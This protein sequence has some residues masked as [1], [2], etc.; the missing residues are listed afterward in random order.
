MTFPYRSIVKH[1]ETFFFSGKFLYLVQGFGTQGTFSDIYSI[2]FGPCSSTCQMQLYYFLSG[3]GLIFYFFTD[4]LHVKWRTI[5]S[6]VPVAVFWFK[7]A[8]SLDIKNIFVLPASNLINFCKWFCS[9]FS[10]E[11]FVNLTNAIF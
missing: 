8:F 2:Q 1:H 11:N 5:I 10:F 6:E 7:S 4:S 3:Q 9:V